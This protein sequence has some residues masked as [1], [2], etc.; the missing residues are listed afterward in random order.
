MRRIIFIAFC[1]AIVLVL[2][3]VVC[4]PKICTFIA[5]DKC[6]DKGCSWNEKKNDCDCE[7]EEKQMRKAIIR[8]TV[9]ARQIVLKEKT[10]TARRNESRADHNLN[11]SRKILPV[12]NSLLFKIWTADH[13]APH[14]DFVIKPHEFYVVDFDGNGSRK[15]KVDGNQ[16]SVF[17]DSHVQRGS[18]LSLTR[19][20]L[21]ILWEGAEQP[22]TYT[23]WKN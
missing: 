23:E 1:S 11:I 15:Y 20:Q 2:V 14:A 12:N 21:V 4:Y 3:T 9:P 19:Q 10:D 16:L 8:K 18:I 7:I 22:V 6:L 5:Q 13:Q 17:Y